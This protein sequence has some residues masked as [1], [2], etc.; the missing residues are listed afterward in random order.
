MC[1]QLNNLHNFFPDISESNNRDY[2][3]AS[4][5]EEDLCYI[6]MQSS[7]KYRQELPLGASPYDYGDPFSDSECNLQLLG[8]SQFRMDSCQG[9]DTESFSDNESICNFQQSEMFQKV[10]KMA[11]SLP[12]EN[13]K[14]K[15]LPSKVSVCGK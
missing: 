15:L 8:N 1:S 11:A 6:P 10:L 5:N 13:L 12:L 3:S 7:L 9:S 14:N 4:L 2:L